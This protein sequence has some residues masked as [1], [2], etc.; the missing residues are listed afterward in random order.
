M[1]YKE[2]RNRCGGAVS[3]SVEIVFSATKQE[4]DEL[5][6]ALNIVQSYTNVARKKSKSNGSDWVETKIYFEKDVVVVKVV[7]GM[8]G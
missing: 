4:Q 5:R 1:K 6:K 7:D 8:A 3:G 2:E